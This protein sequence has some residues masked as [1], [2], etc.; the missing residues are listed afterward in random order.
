MNIF[1]LNRDPLLAAGDHCDKHVLKMIIESAQ[2][3][4][5]AHLVISGFDQAKHDNPCL[6]KPTHQNHPCSLWVRSGPE[7]YSWTLRLL[8]G[9]LREYHTRY[10]PERPH[11]YFGPGNLARSLEKWPD[12]MLIVP[13]TDPPQVVPDAYKRPDAVDAYRA[14]YIGEKAAFAS[15]RSPARVPEWWPR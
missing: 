2:M 14:Y 1:F 3:L 5:T 6:L 13:W 8:D 7:Q 4:S 15:W 12:G 9:L 10:R 11:R